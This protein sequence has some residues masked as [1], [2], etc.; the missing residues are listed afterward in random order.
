MLDDDLARIDAILPGLYRLALGGTAVGTGLKA[1]KG[2]GEAAV[3][4]LAE[5]TGLPLVPAPNKFAV[6]GA[7]DADG[8]GERGPEDRRRLPVQDRQ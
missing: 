3:G 8:H 2:F 1:G 4:L 6:Q 5:I 7:H